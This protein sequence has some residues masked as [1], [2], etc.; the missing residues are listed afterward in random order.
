MAE[1]AAAASGAGLVSLGIQCCKGLTAYYSSYKAYNEQIGGTHEEIEVLKSLFENLE[2]VL[3]RNTADPAQE[4]YVQQ[5]D[6][7][8]TLCRGRLQNL[9]SVLENCQSIALP[10]SISARLQKIKSQALFP[11]KEQTLLTLRENV[12]SLRGDLQFALHVFQAYVPT[13]FTLA[14]MLNVTFT[15]TWKWSKRKVLQI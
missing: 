5:V 12:Q 10:S 13:L 9:Q 6:A 2:R 15:V 4:S 1:L 8:I 3:S 11:F 7:I 14:A